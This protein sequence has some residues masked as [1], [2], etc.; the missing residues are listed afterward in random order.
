MSLMIRNARHVVAPNGNSP[1]PLTSKVK[2]SY[3]LSDGL[4]SGPDPIRT[5]LRILRSRLALGQIL[6]KAHATLRVVE[7]VLEFWTTG[8]ALLAEWL[9]PIQPY[10]THRDLV[11]GLYEHGPDNVELCDVKDT[12]V[13]ATWIS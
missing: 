1:Q 6:P 8:S 2:R 3:E 13:G 7:L 9:V 12:N 10:F 4:R 11:V 5:T